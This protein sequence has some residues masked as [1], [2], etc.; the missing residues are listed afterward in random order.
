M[1]PTPST[2]PLNPGDDAAPGTP[3]TGEDTCPVCHGSGKISDGN[4]CP[5]CGGSGTITE[6]IGGG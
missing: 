6:G 5:N 1:D 3:G 4:S 2:T